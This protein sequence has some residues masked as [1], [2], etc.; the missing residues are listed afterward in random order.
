MIGSENVARRSLPE[1]SFLLE[2]G[3]AGRWL[4]VWLQ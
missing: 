3:P 4:R 1:L 2:N